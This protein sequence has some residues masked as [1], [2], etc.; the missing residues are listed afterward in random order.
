MIRPAEAVASLSL[1]VVPELEADEGDATLSRNESAFRP[2]PN[3]IAAA[4][5]LAPEVRIYPDPNWTELRKAIAEVHSLDQE[6]I[7]CGM[8]SLELIACLARAYAAAGDDVLVTDHCY[9]FVATAAA[10]A[11]ARI[12]RAREIDFTVSGDRIAAAVT[13]ATR[14]AFVCNPGNPTGTAIPNSEIV[15]LRAK[16]PDD[17]LLVIDQAYGEFTDASDSPLPAFDLVAGGNTVVLRTFSKAYALAGARVGWGY[18]P[19]AVGRQVRKLLL[20]NSVAA[21]SQAMALAAVRDQGHMRRTVEK[22]EELRDGFREQALSLGIESP[23]S[24]TNF[25]LLKF[26]GV[27]AADAADRTLK[28]DGLRLR[29]MSPSGLPECLRA[30][31]CAAPV[32]GR[33][34]G[35]L[36]KAM[37]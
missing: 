16:L 15:R 32:M 23:A 21:A 3:A 31:V 27:E 7:L 4:R 30:T 10:Q 26:P 37:Q 8:G 2:S 34:L 11:G 18:F 13:P 6:S 22:T 5:D 9:A 24:R 20:P 14:I 12:A 17:L 19:P 33:A 35:A 29:R 25:V 28:A 36:R 1:Y